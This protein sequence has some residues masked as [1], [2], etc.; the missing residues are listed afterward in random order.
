[1]SSVLNINSCLF[2]KERRWQSF[3][4]ESNVGCTSRFNFDNVTLMSKKLCQHNNK[5][6][7]SEIN[8]YNIA[9]NEVKVFVI[10]YRYSE[11]TCIL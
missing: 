6:D 3:V 8:G 5:F 2:T 7:C 4:K 10:K 1:M 11:I 9:I